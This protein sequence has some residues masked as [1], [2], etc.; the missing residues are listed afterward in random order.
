MENVFIYELPEKIFI[1]NPVKA[2]ITGYHPEQ[3]EKNKKIQVVKYH[4]PYKPS[5]YETE[6]CKSKKYR[7]V[8]RNYSE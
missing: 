6:Y 7:D 3:R 8:K 5:L 2:E 1:F 4:M